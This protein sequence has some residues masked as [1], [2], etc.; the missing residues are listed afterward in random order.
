[1]YGGIHE[2]IPVPAVKMFEE[3]INYRENRKLE[4]KVEPPCDPYD[5]LSCIVYTSWAEQS[6]T[7]DLIFPLRLYY[8]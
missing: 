7:Q 4:Y 3:N 8:I 5:P 1:L 6:H 2:Q